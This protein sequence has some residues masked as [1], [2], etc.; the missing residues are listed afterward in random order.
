MGGKSRLDWRWND[1]GEMQVQVVQQGHITSRATHVG[2]LLESRDLSDDATDDGSEFLSSGISC[3][4]GRF[5]GADVDPVDPSVQILWWCRVL[6]RLVL[7][8]EAARITADSLMTVPLASTVPASLIRSRAGPVAGQ[9]PTGRHMTA[10]R[11]QPRSRPAG[12]PGTDPL[13]SGPRCA[14]SDHHVPPRRKP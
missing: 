11:Q 1:G 5:M 12:N 10:Q 9:L 3:T 13:C 6:L 7:D 8:A 14:E 4:G 2:L